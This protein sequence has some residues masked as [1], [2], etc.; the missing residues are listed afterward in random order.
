MPYGLFDYGGTIN[1]LGAS[2]PICPGGGIPTLTTYKDP[3]LG[4]RDMGFGKGINGSFKCPPPKMIVC[5]DGFVTSTPVG[6]KTVVD[7]CRGRYKCAP[8]LKTGNC[9]YKLA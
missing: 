3:K 4:N 2:P 7:P 8:T 1:T 9:L 6:S 5:E